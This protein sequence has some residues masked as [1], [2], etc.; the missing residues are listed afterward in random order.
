MSWDDVDKKRGGGSSSFLKLEAGEAVQFRVLDESPHTAYVHK[1][2]QQVEKDDDSGETQEVFRTIP[3][4]PDLDD[5]YI[6]QNST[7]WPAEPVFALRVYAYGK[8]DE[9]EVK[10]LQGGRQIFKQL[11]DLYESNGD[12]REFDCKLK[13]EGKGR[14]TKYTVTA[15][16]RSKDI[17][18]EEIIESFDDSLDFDVL[19][20]S[21]TAEDQKRMLKEAKL[22]IAYDPAREIA[23][24]MDLDDALDVRVTFG[25][26]KGKT[27]GELVAIDAGY[28]EWMADNVS[29]DD[30]IRAAAMI[31]AERLDEIDAPKPKKALPKPKDDK[32]SKS[33]KKSAKPAS[34]DDDEQEDD[35]PARTAASKK[36]DAKK[37]PA[38]QA[39]SSLERDALMEKV[40]DV[41][42]NNEKYEDAMEIVKVIK[43]HGNGKTRIK[44]LNEEQLRS[45]LDD[46]E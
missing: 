17:D 6:E 30:T 41:F 23:E 20:P 3:A 29:S 5:D 7:R 42:E 28:V 38:S 37:K 19:F 34:S 39:K 27:I 11:K 14:D 44:D 22:D 9:G 33:A 25:K 40:N 1:I 12:L 8:D 46:I 10:V 21:V 18:V 13:R 2:T 43:K 36:A 4:T 35:K 31:A 45:L 24:N 15:V 32:K 16:V 26:Y